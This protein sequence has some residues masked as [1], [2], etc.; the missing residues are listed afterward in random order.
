MFY[1]CKELSDNDTLV[2]IDD[3]QSEP[4]LSLFEDFIFNKLNEHIKNLKT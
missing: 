3:T 2:L 4:L 1:N